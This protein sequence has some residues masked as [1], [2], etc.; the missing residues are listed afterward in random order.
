MGPKRWEKAV[1]DVVGRLQAAMVADYVVL[2]GG[3]TKLLKKLPENCRPGSNRNALI[4][5]V[6]LWEEQF[7]VL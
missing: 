7:R 2:G 1:H 5:G 4:G 3:N 6:R